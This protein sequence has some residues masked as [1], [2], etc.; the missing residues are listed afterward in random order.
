MINRLNNNIKIDYFRFNIYIF[1]EKTFI[2]DTNQMKNLKKCVQL[3][4]NDLKNRINATSVLLIVSFYFELQA[5]SYFENEN[6]ACHHTIQCRN[7]IDEI[8]KFFEIYHDNQSQFF[9]NANFFELLSCFDICAI[10]HIYNK[11]I[12]FH[13]NQLKNTI[14]IKLKLNAQK[15]TKN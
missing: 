7:N 12:S 14:T 8:L 11:T 13:V 9:I 1:T 6:Y 2:D 5:I 4:F 10:C 15:K 3:F